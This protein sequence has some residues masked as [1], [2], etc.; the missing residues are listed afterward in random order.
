M[1]DISFYEADYLFDTGRANDLA[2]IGATMPRVITRDSTIVVNGKPQF[3]SRPS[4]PCPRCQQELRPGK[5][6][7]HFKHA[8]ADRRDQEVDALVCQCG[9]AYVSGEIARRAYGRAMTCQASSGTESQ[10][11]PPSSVDQSRREQELRELPTAEL[12]AIV[13]F[14]GLTKDQLRLVHAIASERL[15]ESQSLAD[16]VSTRLEQASTAE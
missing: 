2:S 7:I 16:E 10:V 5:A 6:T 15:H 1:N 13:E 12:A 8:P 14:G 9:E 4:I 3:K 11:A